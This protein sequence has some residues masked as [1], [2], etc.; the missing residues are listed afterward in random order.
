VARRTLTPAERREAVD[1]KLVAQNQAAVNDL[2]IIEARARA[3]V[4]DAK[5]RLRVAQADLDHVLNV[6]I[7]S[8]NGR[9]PKA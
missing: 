9:P 8:A 5:E 2:P 1:R 4:E 6:E 7:P 3:R